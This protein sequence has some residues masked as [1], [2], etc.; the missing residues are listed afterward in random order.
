MS[1]ED[2]RN[3]RQKY[4]ENMEAQRREMLAKE[5]EKAVQ[6]KADQVVDSAGGWLEC[7]LTR[8]LYLQS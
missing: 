6:G 4:A 5:H 2:E 7:E 1:D 3:A 8:T